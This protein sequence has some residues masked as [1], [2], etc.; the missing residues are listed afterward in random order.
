[1]GSGHRQNVRLFLEGREVPFVGAAIVGKPGQALF[2]SIDMVPTQ[3]IKFIRPRTQVHIFVRDNLA[4][5]NDGYYLAFDGECFGRTMEKKHDGRSFSISALDFS[6]YIQE[7]KTYTLSPNF[8]PTLVDGIA[9]NGEPSPDQLLKAIAGKS[10]QTSS[11]SNHKLI[12]I[13]LSKPDILDG[14]VA[15]VDYLKSANIFYQCAFERLRIMDRINAFSSGR[16]KEF[17]SGL[18]VQQFLNDFMGAHGGMGS[19]MDL[20]N[21]IM[22]LVFHDFVSIPFPALV[23]IRQAGRTGDTIGNF[24]YIP[25]GYTLPAPMCNVIFPSQQSGFSFQEDFRAVPTRY[26]FRFAHP[27]MMNDSVTF[28]TYPMQVYPTSFSNY[29]FGS[30]DITDAEAKS[31]LGP[32]SFYKDKNGHTYAQVNYGKPTEGKSVGTTNN[33][34]FREPDFLTNEESIKGIYFEIDTFM[35]SYTSLVLNSDP[36]ARQKFTKEVG[37]YLY[38]K[39]R[40]AA[41]NVTA[42]IKFNPFLVPGF[43][44]IF[45]DDSDA[46]QTFVA[47]LQSVV[48]HLSNQ[49]CATQVELGYGRD[50]DEIDALTGQASEPT[51]PAWFD[52]SIFGGKD[53]ELYKREVEYLKK[54]GIINATEAKR[55]LSLEGVS[56]YGNLGEKF[57][58]PLLGVGS[59]VDIV[60]NK[61]KENKGNSPALAT[62]RGAVEYIINRYRNLSQDEK[63][64]EKFI[65]DVTQRP[66]VGIS[67]AF[68]FLGAAPVGTTNRPGSAIIPDEYAQFVGTT[69]PPLPQ[70]FDGI[71]YPDELVLKERRG[72]IDKYVAQLRSRRGFRG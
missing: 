5:G 14:I 62:T 44:A 17:L 40:Y 70:R 41:R 21:D 52:E 11:T 38:F 6:S 43:N 29:M 25:D 32:S 66:L 19:L 42:S 1:M 36:E 13:I 31:M 60:K 33:L 9:Q 71:G 72:I 7:S 12:E 16:I 47:K 57:Y 18:N 34:S 45:L 46:G 3:V 28:P 65:R 2:A 24:M 4:F 59:V 61:D 22:K 23:P 10:I 48:H 67:Q 58:K 26:A 54:L 55:R 64:R 37:K 15:V 69:I 49:G 56:T 50:F 68:K 30:K 39:H 27:V 20:L 51:Q 35:P 53:K 8:V 63:A